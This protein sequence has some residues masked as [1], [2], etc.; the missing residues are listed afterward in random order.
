M[1]KQIKWAEVWI[2]SASRGE[3][4]LILRLVDDCLEV[5]D[6]Q[7]QSKVVK[8]FEDYENAVHW[9]NEDEYD[10]IEGRWMVEH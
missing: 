5:V 1:S 7:N 2:D 3:Y 10:M 6:P 4:V 9:L 8:T